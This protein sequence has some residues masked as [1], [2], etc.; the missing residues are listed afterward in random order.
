MSLAHCENLKQQ[1]DKSAVVVVVVVV[2]VQQQQQQQRHEPIASL[3]RVP[4]PTP[5]QKK[6]PFEASTRCVSERIHLGG[7]MFMGVRLCWAVLG[8]TLRM[9]QNIPN[10][11]KAAS[12][13]LSG[14]GLLKFANSEIR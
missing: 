8:G 10:Y 12:S 3:V 6:F 4:T 1:Q 9:P 11:T 7:V 5:G 14:S 2:A 13:S